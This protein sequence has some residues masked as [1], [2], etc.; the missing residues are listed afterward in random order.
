MNL[1]RVQLKIL[2]VAERQVFIFLIYS[3]VKG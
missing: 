1:V 3:K 2:D